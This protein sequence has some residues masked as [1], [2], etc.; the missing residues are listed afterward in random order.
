[1]ADTVTVDDGREARKTTGE[2][3]PRV[4]QPNPVFA[5]PPRPKAI[6]KYLFGFPGYLWPFNALFAG[7]AIVTW[8][9]L[10]PSADALSELDQLRAR[11]IMP[12]YARN[13]GFLL[14]IAGA[15]HLR[16]YWARAQGARFKYNGRWPSKKSKAFLFGNQVW[17]N[18]FW[19]LVSGAGIW[20][21][22]EALLLWAYGNG[23]LPF[24]ELRTHPVWCVAWLLLIPVWNELHF[25]WSHRILHW[26]PLYKAAHYL[27]HRNVNVGPW[28]GLSMHPLEHLIYFSQWLILLVVPSHPIHMLYVMQ[29]TA[30]TPAQGHSGFDQLVLEKEGDTRMSIDSFFHYLHHRHFECNYGNN[31]TPMDRWFGSFHDGTPEALAAMRRKRRMPASIHTAS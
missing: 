12:M 24:I 15:W 2:W 17:D 4:I 3:L 23:W 13:V 20:T 6:V 5:W 8:L 11:W 14:I 30:L 19:S 27:H 29:R 21:I 31:L 16:L 18:M 22:Y 26:K 25:Y 10:Q 7:L 28:S 1:M 9:F